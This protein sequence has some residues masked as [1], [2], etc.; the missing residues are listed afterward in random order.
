MIKAIDKKYC[1]DNFVQLMPHTDDCQLIMST[2][3]IIFLKVDNN[4]LINK[5]KNH[6]K[7]YLFPY[8]DFEKHNTESSTNYNQ[9]FE[10]NKMYLNYCGSISNFNFSKNYFFKGTNRALFYKETLDYDERKINKSNEKE[11][12]LT[13]KEIHG[14]KQ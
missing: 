5:Y 9:L 10:Y 12:Y 6:P 4:I 14:W 7:R 2:D 11:E 13:K 8:S 3:E 1:I